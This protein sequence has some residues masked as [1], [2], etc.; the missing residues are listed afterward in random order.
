MQKPFLAWGH[1][2]TGSRR[3]GVCSLVTLNLKGEVFLT[4]DALK[5]RMTE[6]KSNHII[7]TLGIR[8]D[9]SFTITGIVSMCLVFIVLVMFKKI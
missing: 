2:Q 9:I 8:L 1:T 5:V 7:F 3:R 6:S 4:P